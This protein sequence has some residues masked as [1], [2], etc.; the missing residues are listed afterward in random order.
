MERYRVD[1]IMKSKLVNSLNASLE[2][3]SH[4]LHLRTPIMQNHSA[5]PV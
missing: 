2:L 3:Q 4:S 5:T 1:T